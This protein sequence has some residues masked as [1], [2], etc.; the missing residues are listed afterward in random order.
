MLVYSIIISNWCARGIAGLAASGNAQN[1]KNRSVF[2]MN[3]A[4][5]DKI[6]TKNISFFVK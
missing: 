2:V 3:P 6:L 4:R 1:G 5:Y